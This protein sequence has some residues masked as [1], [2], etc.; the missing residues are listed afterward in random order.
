MRFRLNKVIEPVERFFEG[1]GYLNEQFEKVPVVGGLLKLLLIVAILAVV[2]GIILLVLGGLAIFALLLN[3][4]A[5][6]ASRI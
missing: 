4:L 5:G 3:D 1:V 6:G 2:F